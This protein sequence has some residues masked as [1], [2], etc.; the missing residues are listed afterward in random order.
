MIYNHWFN[1][2]H[3]SPPLAHQSTTAIKT[4]G[5]VYHS[6]IQNHWVSIAQLDSQPLA[7]NNTT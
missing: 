2:T 5:S 1:I 3:D 6:M 7:Q 4:A